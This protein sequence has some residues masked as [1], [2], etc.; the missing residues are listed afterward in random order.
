M[1]NSGRSQSPAAG[2]HGVPAGFSYVGDPG[3]G[4]VARH[5]DN[6]QRYGRA[7]WGSSGEPMHR[8]ELAPTREPKGAN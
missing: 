6:E 2:R 1:Q 5:R 3:E 7:R 4:K 8:A